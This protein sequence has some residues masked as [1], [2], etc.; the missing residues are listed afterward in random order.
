M[1]LR[2][3]VYRYS[4]DEACGEWLLRQNMV[5]MNIITSNM[6]TI[7]TKSSPDERIERAHVRFVHDRLPSSCDLDV[8]VLTGS[9]SE[10]ELI[11]AYTTHANAGD[12]ETERSR[13]G[14]RGHARVRGVL[15]IRRATPAAY[16][17]GRGRRDSATGVSLRSLG[18]SRWLCGHDP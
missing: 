16:R 8:I 3:L 11:Q 6:T 1:V 4:G 7:R 12:H 2:G 14:Y 10:R 9:L 13:R 18:T 17:R 5:P 15:A